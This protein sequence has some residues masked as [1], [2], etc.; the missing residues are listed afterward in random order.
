MRA[1]AEDWFDQN[2]CQTLLKAFWRDPES[3]ACQIRPAFLKYE[4]CAAIIRLGD[5]LL[6][7][8]FIQL[9]R[10]RQYCINIYFL[11]CF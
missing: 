6:Q 2:L 11:G 5:I 4:K 10:V 1:Y 9:K 7:N 8:T 3:A